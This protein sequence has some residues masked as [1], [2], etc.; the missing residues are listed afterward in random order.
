VADM[1]F[2]RRMRIYSKDGDGLAVDY[3]SLCEIRMTNTVDGI[4][5]GKPDGTEDGQY[6]SLYI[7]AYEAPVEGYT[8]AI[9]LYR[10]VRG[11]KAESNDDKHFLYYFRI[12][13]QTNEMGQVTNA[14]YGKIYGQINGSFSYFLN[15]T[16]N[17]RNV[18]FDP[19]KNL[20]T[21]LGEFEQVHRP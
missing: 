2:T 18:E 13:T 8:S 20:F 10:N 12:R 3:D 9:S 16:P 11:T 15:P 14:L 17:D 5:L 21:T 19:K 7:S 4:C 6:G 1:Q